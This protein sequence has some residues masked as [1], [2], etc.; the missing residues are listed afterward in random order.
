MANVIENP[1][2]NSPYDAPTRYWKFDDA[3]ITDQVLGVWVRIGFQ[4]ALN[5]DGTWK[6]PRVEKSVFGVV[7]HDQ[8]W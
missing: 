7:W 6:S 5:S 3:G 4:P 2:L 1:I 8:L